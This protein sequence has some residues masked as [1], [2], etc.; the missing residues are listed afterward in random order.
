[1]TE[2]WH[3][4]L[5]A[6]WWA[7]FNEGGPEVEFFRSYVEAG[8][9][10]L[11]LGCGTGRLLL[12]WLRAGL[13]VD[14]C[15]MSADMIALCREVAD[16]EGLT[17]NLYAQAMH[18]LDL[19][20]RY[21]TIVV[22]GALGLGGRREDTREGLR[23]IYEQL[24]PGGTF[25]VDNEVPYVGG[26]VWKAWQ[27]EARA[28]LPRPWGEPGERRVGSDGSEYALRG[29]LV[30]LDPLEQQTT[31]EMRAWMWRDGELIAVEEHRLDMTLYFTHEIELMLELT[32]F[33]DVEL[34]AGYADRLPT[35]DDDFVVFVARKP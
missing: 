1:M 30:A 5:I 11:D 16:R 27:E 33:V 13:D 22:C 14:G 12:P 29:R 17:T 3:H 15:D 20:R 6:K 7:E 32:G 21:R 28:E 10:A 34:R 25:V 8:Q 35:A 19:P 4:G 9:P 26:P 18:E 24:E 2:T 31:W 23:R